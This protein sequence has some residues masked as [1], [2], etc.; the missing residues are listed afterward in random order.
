M[1]HTTA[2]TIIV[3]LDA[4]VIAALAYVCWI[5]FQLDRRA[6]EAQHRLTGFNAES[7]LVPELDLA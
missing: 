4:F 3:A 7:E 2:V 1:S 5:P 6:T